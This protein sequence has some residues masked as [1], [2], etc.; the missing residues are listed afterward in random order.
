MVSSKCPKLQAIL[1][2]LTHLCQVDSCTITLWSNL[3]LISSVSGWS[4]LLSR[5]KELSELNA[6]NV[7][8]DQTSDLGLHCLQMSLSWDARLKWVKA[9]TCGV[10]FF[11]SVSN[12]S[13]SK[14]CSSHPC[15]TNFSL[16]SPSPFQPMSPISLLM[17]FPPLACVP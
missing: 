9:A 13:P 14:H 1:Y 16:L 3:F 2:H 11:S 12:L 17:L 10:F 4:L 5:L 7:D 8:P 6:N 15:T